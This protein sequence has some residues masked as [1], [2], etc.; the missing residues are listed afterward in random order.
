MREGDTAQQE[1]QMES[2]ARGGVLTFSQELLFLWLN[3]SRELSWGEKAG[4]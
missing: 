3:G 1:G 4:I 2:N